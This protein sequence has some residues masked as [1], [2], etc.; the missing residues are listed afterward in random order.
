MTLA[1]E[2]WMMRPYTFNVASVFGGI[3]PP[4]WAVVIDNKS[5]HAIYGN[6]P[7]GQVAWGQVI[8]VVAETV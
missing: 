7:N 8:G 5:T 4:R 2:G 1:D 6:G 3:V